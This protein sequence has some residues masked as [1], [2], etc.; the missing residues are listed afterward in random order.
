LEQIA[1]RL[2]AQEMRIGIIETSNAVEQLR[3]E[4]ESLWARIPQA[5]PF[6]N[7]DWLLPW[8]RHIG[9]GQLFFLTIRDGAE[10]VG[11]APFYVH[12]DGG[13]RQLTLLGNGVSDTCDLLIDPNCPGAEA[14]LAHE[15]ERCGACW[16][17]YDF[18][19]LP[20]SS[21]LIHLCR[22]GVCG[23]LSEDTPCVVLGLANWLAGGER[24]P[25]K[26]LL[27]DLRRC[28]RRA[29]EIG[30]VRIELTQGDAVSD[31]LEA[32]FQIHASRWNALGASG[33]LC[34]A[35]VQAFHHEVAER[36]ARRGWLRLCRLYVGHRLAAVTYGFCVRR[37]AY[38]Y[39]GG[40]DPEFSRLGAG[41]IILDEVIRQAAQE[42]A[43]EFDFLRGEEGY[44]LRWGGRPRPQY[45]VKSPPVSHVSRDVA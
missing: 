7:P 4:W 25:C 2:L 24:A 39:I 16:D 21:I 33:M 40:F 32:L 29:E 8:W 44:K 18:R 36:F 41:R 23:T 37:R 43:A 12:S 13:V 6:Q 26:K 14:A 10:L 19:D 22:G 38:Y 3:P 11:I 31:A 15:I 35:S 5:G 30:P 17:C 1:E 45:R 34:G 28:R 20:A 42:G 27:A 9:N